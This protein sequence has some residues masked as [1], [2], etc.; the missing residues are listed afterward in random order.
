[1]L[2]DYVNVFKTILPSNYTN[3]GTEFGKV[4]LITAGNNIFRQTLMQLAIKSNVFVTWNSAV[5]ALLRK[6]SNI[7]LHVGK[8]D[9]KNLPSRILLENLLK[10]KALVNDSLPT[11]RDF[12]SIP[13]LHTDD[14]KTQITGSQLTKHPLQLKIDTANN[15]NINVRHL[16]GNGLHPNQ[17]GSKCFSKNFP[18]TIEKF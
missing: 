8:N 9:A 11:C 5:H 12:I 4:T 3:L 13:T 18:N 1:M 17:S 15:N 7:I 6:S 14:G 2:L 16:G 10:L